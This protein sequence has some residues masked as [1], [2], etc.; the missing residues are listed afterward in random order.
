MISGLVLTLVNSIAFQVH[1]F[2]PIHIYICTRIYVCLFECVYLLKLVMLLI[3][4]TH[5]SGVW[6]PCPISSRGWGPVW[7]QSGWW[8]Y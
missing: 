1:C 2:D 8:S 7:V 5:V 3:L 4:L 6:N